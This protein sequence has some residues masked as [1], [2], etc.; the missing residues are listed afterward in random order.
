MK[1]RI[2]AV[3]LLAVLLMGILPGAHA[4][5]PLFFVA[6]NNDI[7]VLLSGDTSPFY[8]NGLLYAPYT[9]FDANPGGVNVSYA[10]DQGIFALFTLS[11]TVVYDLNENTLSTKSGTTTN[12]EVIFRNGVLY[13]P[14]EQAAAQFGLSVS[15]INSSSGCTVLRFKDG[16]EI[17]DDQT[18][19]NKSEMFISHMIDTY[20]E[21]GFEDD[22]VL[23]NEP[24]EQE[25][26]EP[27][28]GSAEI[29]L[30]FTGDAVSQETLGDLEAL[31]Y[32]LDRSICAAFFLTETQ[33]Q[34]NRQLVRD[35]YTAGHQIGLTPEPGEDIRSS[36]IAANQA[37]DGVLYMKA[38]LVLLDGESPEL[39]SYRVIH[40]NQTVSTMEQV[41]E[42]PEIPSLLLCDS[43]A[44]AILEQ[45]SLYEVAVH[46]LLETTVLQNRPAEE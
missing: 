2:V 33:I 4:A 7:P 24:A 28:V 1:K 19:L 27:V 32:L 31:S 22:P 26:E 8:T 34:E 10:V 46:R 18:F 23:E 45:I 9:V 25:E 21:Q 41:L 5:G 11:N 44:V 39:P 12:V 20:G 37:L 35:I 6:V 16:T 42:Y 38:V 3:V 15:L 13:L 14:I 36:L 30:A 43:D 40:R 17:Y 29:F